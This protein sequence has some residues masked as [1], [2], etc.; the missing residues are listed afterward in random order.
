MKSVIYEIQISF[1]DYLEVGLIT[2]T[3]YKIHNSRSQ[4]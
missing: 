1:N 3:E 4:I 2:E